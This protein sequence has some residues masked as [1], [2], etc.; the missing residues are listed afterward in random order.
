MSF[1]D[2]T[3]FP[4]MCYLRDFVDTAHV[5]HV[6][7]KVGNKILGNFTDGCRWL[8]GKWWVFFRPCRCLHLQKATLCFPLHEK[9]PSI[10]LASDPPKKTQ[11][12]H[13]AN[14]NVNSV[15]DNKNSGRLLNLFSQIKLKLQQLSN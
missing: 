1:E 14:L 8:L 6:W 7:G 15:S 9:F 4:G 5:A 13:F 3:S 12:E 10:F 2:L 11:K